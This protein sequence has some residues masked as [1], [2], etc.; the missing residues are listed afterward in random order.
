MARAPKITWERLRHMIESGVGSGFGEN[1]QPWIQIKRWNPSPV[2]TQ[3]VKPLPPFK[4]PCHFLSKAEYS[5]ALIF[6]WIGC[7]FREQFP[8]WPWPHPHPETGRNILV[9][10]YLNESLGLIHLCDQA[11]IEHGNFIGTSIPYIWTIDFCL[12]LPWVTAR[13]SSTCLVSVKP[14]NSMIAKVGN[15]LDRT[16]EKLEIERRYTAEINAQYLIGDHKAFSSTLIGNLDRI[17]SCAHIPR[18]HKAYK[19]AQAFL[20][21]NEH[22]LASEPSS[23]AYQTLMKSFGCDEKTAALIQNHLVWHQVI[24]CDLSK[25]LVADKPPT[26]GGRKL[27]VSI[28]KNLE[29]AK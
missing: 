2:S 1:Y 18:T 25:P 23:Y 10:T 8:L 14:M 3:V 20:D 4:R 21:Q 29:A 12:H 15:A 11:G 17:H 19:I 6:S 28:Q 27:K 9:D 5:L 22:R 13:S 16:L 24:D 7:E 26:P